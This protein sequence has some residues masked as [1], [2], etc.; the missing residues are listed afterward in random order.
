MANKISNFYKNV[1]GDTRRVVQMRIILLLTVVL[2]LLFTVSL[3]ITNTSPSEILRRLN[4]NDQDNYGY[5][6]S[7]KPSGPVNW[8]VSIP[9]G[10]SLINDGAFINEN[11][12][13]FYDRHKDQYIVNI[14]KGDEYDYDQ[15]VQF[16]E[17]K[18]LNVK[19]IDDQKYLSLS[20]VQYID[21]RHLQYSN[22][23]DEV[24]TDEILD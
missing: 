7:D 12:E 6:A 3:K 15:L 22:I 1:F 19:E 21:Q 13:L 17:S 5:G 2:I 14:L 24:E 8:N 18:L 10:Y 11:F 4:N 16:I 20:K 23:Y 9:E